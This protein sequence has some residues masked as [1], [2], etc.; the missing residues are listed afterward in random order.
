MYRCW[1]F[2]VYMRGMDVSRC[3][4]VG[5]VVWFFCAPWLDRRSAFPF[6]V[7]F[8]LERASSIVVQTQTRGLLARALYT[9]QRRAAVLF[10][11]CFREPAASAALGRGLCARA[12]LPHVP[13]SLRH[14][15]HAL[16]LPRLRSPHLP[17]FD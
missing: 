4:S 2:V 15:P 17:L 14:H 7:Q 10:E 1:F 12:P 8:L 11:V 16:A 3:V 5:S 9:R 6:T 13:A